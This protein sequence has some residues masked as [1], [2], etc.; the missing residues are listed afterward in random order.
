[1]SARLWFA[2]MVAAEVIVVLGALA[3]FAMGTVAVV[4][5]A[6]RRREQEAHVEVRPEWKTDPADGMPAPSWPERDR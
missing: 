2:A 1:V 6:R 4:R 3:A 5:R